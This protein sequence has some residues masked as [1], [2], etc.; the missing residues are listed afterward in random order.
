MSLLHVFDGPPWQQLVAFAAL[1]LLG[2]IL[3]HLVLLWLARRYRSNDRLLPVGPYF[4]AVTVIFGLFVGFL[5]SDIWGRN[6]HATEAAYQERSALATYLDIVGPDGLDSPEAMTAALRYR[7]TVVQDEWGAGRNDAPLPETEAALRA[8][9]LAAVAMA[10]DPAAPAAIDELFV[11]LDDI[12]QARDVRLSIGANHG[13]SNAWFTVVVL[14][15]FSFIAIA[16]VHM[17]RPAAGTLTLTIF[18]LATFLMLWFLALHDS[19]Y[20]GGV[21]LDAGLIAEVAPPS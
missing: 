4:V 11:T 9:L 19:P 20:T 12:A 21:R 5:A 17:D 18:A 1:A 3:G 6:H 7:D 15:L 13:G 8:M 2:W 14:Y 10:R 16:S